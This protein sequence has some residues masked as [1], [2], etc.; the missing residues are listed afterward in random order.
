[1]QVRRLHG[2]AQG[3][4]KTVRWAEPTDGGRET[5]DGRQKERVDGVPGRRTRTGRAEVGVQ[6]IRGPGGGRWCRGGLMES[7]RE[8]VSGHADGSVQQPCT[9][10]WLR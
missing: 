4:H 2:S 7:G 3:R 9:S 10:P 5:A 1:V 8:V 6:R